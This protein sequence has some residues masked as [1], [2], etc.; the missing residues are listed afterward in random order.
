[1]MIDYHC[2]Q[3]IKI[4]NVIWVAFPPSAPACHSEVLEE[5]IQAGL[6]IQYKNIISYQLEP[7]TNNNNIKHK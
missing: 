1:M 2:H 6:Q 7:I 5:S 3:T 4:I